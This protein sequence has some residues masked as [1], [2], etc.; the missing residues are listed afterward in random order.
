MQAFPL[1]ASGTRS[2][3]AGV[4][5]ASMHQQR[6]GFQ[7]FYASLVCLLDA[8]LTLLDLSFSSTLLQ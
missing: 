4:N 8:A 1:A 7:F 3:T 2:I 6:S 5:T